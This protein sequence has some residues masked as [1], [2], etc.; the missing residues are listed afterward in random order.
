MA[1]RCFLQEEEEVEHQENGLH[2]QLDGKVEGEEVT[3]M[4]TKYVHPVLRP[5]RSVTPGRSDTS[6]MCPYI[7][8]TPAI[9]PKPAA[10]EY[11]AK[12]AADESNTTLIYPSLITHLP[13]K[14]LLIPPQKMLQS[15]KCNPVVSYRQIKDQKQNLISAD[16][17]QSQKGSIF[18][19]WQ[20][21]YQTTK[22]LHNFGNEK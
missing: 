21:K 6:Q 17:C 8:D 14:I 12:T 22:I 20:Q 9:G 10:V 7:R 19:V 3:E 11:L 5:T 1:A 16:M 15:P 2:Q 18:T 4:K 13:I